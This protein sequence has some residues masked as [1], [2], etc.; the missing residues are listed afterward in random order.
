MT[1]RSPSLSLPRCL[2]VCFEDCPTLGDQQGAH[3]ESSSRHYSFYVFA[4]LVQLFMSKFQIKKF[5]INDDCN[6]INSIKQY[7]V[8]FQRATNFLQRAIF[9][10]RATDFFFWIK[11]AGKTYKLTF[12]NLSFLSFT[13]FKISQFKIQQFLN[14]FTYDVAR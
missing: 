13:V 1:D 2:F 7:R 10:Q 9:L 4:R 6:P 14:F 11:Q 5:A 12:P 3:Y 8:V